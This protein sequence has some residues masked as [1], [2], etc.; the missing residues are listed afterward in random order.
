MCSSDLLDKMALDVSAIRSHLGSKAKKFDPAT[1]ILVD[2]GVPFP[3][4]NVPREF[5]WF[6]D[7]LGSGVSLD[8]AAYRAGYTRAEGLHIVAKMSA[9]GIVS[10]RDSK[11]MVST[12]HEL[13]VPEAFPGISKKGGLRSRE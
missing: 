8:A 7:Q 2:T 10:V 4:M 1:T 13:L 6:R 11:G 5:M 12:A 3:G 9:A